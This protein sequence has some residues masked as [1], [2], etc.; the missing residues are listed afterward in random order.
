MI[1][2]VSDWFDEFWI[3][4]AKICDWPSDNVPPGGVSET[5]GGGD[6]LIDALADPLGVATLVAVKVTVCAVA[7]TCGA[8]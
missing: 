7:M 6:K 3:V 5:E 4:A 8:V 2:Q 1:D